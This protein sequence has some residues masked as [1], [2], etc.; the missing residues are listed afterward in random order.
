MDK[1]V[2]NNTS[3]EV[4]AVFLDGNATAT[5]SQEILA[6]LADD[7]ELRELLHISQLVDSEL[8]A[9]DNSCDYIPMTAMAASCNEDAYC[10]LE[11]EKHIMKLLDVEY[12]EEQFHSLYANH[13]A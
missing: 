9:S 7:A 2:N 4:I 12:D 13:S 6:A 10:C 1:K 8:G 5:E 3:A 11:C